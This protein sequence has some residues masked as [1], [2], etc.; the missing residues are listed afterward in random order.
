MTVENPTS[1]AQE[2]V[3]NLEDIRTLP[4]VAIRVSQLASQ[5]NAEVR[6]IEELVRMDPVL[7]SRVLRMVNSAYFGLRNPVES[8]SKA[9][10]FIGLKN[11]RNL[12]VVDSLRGFFVEEDDDPHFSR[13][14][15]WRHGVAV[16]MSAQLIASRLYGSPGEDAFLGGMLHDIGLMVEDQAVPDLLRQSVGRYAVDENQTLQQCENDIIGT[17]HALVGEC[18]AER[19]GFP[20]E[21]R[22][23]LASHHDVLRDWSTLAGLG[24][25]VQIAEYVADVAGYPL[26]EGRIDL[27][28]G[29]VES[30]IYERQ[31]DYQILVD[32]LHGQIDRATA[33]YEERGE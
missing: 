12:V 26:V 28:S 2:I 30:H 3:E 10:I 17:N 23:A 14:R 16:G 18:I 21:I 5:E 9:I 11:L 33:I 29:I 4:D 13:R 27:P 7:V 25:Q 8:I 22:D 1:R 19:W 6:R 20:E 24:A 15:L 32:D 31:E